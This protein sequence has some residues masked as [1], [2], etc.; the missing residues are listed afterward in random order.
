MVPDNIIFLHIPII[1][2]II[3][4]YA[5]FKGGLIYILGMSIVLTQY[6]AASLTCSQRTHADPKWFL[7]IVLSPTVQMR[8]WCWNV[9]QYSNILCF[10]LAFDSDL[11]SDLPIGSVVS[12]PAISLPHTLLQPESQRV[13]LLPDSGTHRKTHDT[14]SPRPAIHHGQMYRKPTFNRP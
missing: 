6:Q 1:P 5:V 2:T 12:T 4:Q 9:L 7:T 8:S 13:N 10:S 14:Y 3:P 11:V